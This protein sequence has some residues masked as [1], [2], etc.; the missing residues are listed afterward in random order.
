MYMSKIFQVKSKFS[1]VAMLT[2]A[3]KAGQLE[4]IIACSQMRTK[5]H[6]G[7]WVG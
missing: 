7:G 3:R 2:G 4:A 6:L 1:L 5:G